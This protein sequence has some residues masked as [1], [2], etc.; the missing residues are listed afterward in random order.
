MMYDGCWEIELEASGTTVRQA[1]AGTQARRPAAANP[2][3]CRIGDA[4]VDDSSEKTSRP[5]YYIIQKVVNSLRNKSLETQVQR[6]DGQAGV[7]LAT[8]CSSSRGYGY[9][10]LEGGRGRGGIVAL[11]PIGCEYRL[12][13]LW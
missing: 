4:A 10:R 13:G 9:R 1:H 6:A 2:I 3:Y 5:Q 8:R 7:P 11:G 12:A